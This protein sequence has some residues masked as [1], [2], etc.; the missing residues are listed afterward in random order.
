MNAT[1]SQ[2]SK[3]TKVII[4]LD[5]ASGKK[6]YF[7]EDVTATIQFKSAKF[8]LPCSELPD[9]FWETV[10]LNGLNRKPFSTTVDE[11]L[12]NACYDYTPEFY[13][14][15]VKGVWDCIEQLKKDVR[16]D[17]FDPK[18]IE[19]GFLR[20]WNN[21][22]DPEYVYYSAES[23]ISTANSMI[24][25]F[26]A[27]SIREDVPEFSAI[28]KFDVEVAKELD[29]ELRNPPTKWYFAKWINGGD[30]TGFNTFAQ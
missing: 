19:D 30:G 3:N 4:K 1:I 27:D 12:V 23:A 29:M 2:N 15:D 6:E 21:S 7:P 28:D 16:L 14:K 24:E 10:V 5:Y 9:S 22:Q 20:F 17:Q 13:L 25:E 11:L 8:E 26:V 18:R